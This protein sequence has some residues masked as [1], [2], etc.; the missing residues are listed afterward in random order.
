VKT[1][2]R[3]EMEV[4]PANRELQ[5]GTKAAEVR[6]ANKHTKHTVSHRQQ[7]IPCTGYASS[8]TFHTTPSL[9]RLDARTCSGPV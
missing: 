4:R 7:H 8:R 5:N 9:C 3:G 2:K 1:V 6:T